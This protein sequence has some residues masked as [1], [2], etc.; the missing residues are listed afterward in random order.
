MP[1]RPKPRCGRALFVCPRRSL[2]AFGVLRL[3][4]DLVGQ[5]LVADAAWTPRYGLADL[6]GAVDDLAL[7]PGPHHRDMLEQFGDVLVRL[8]LLEMNDIRPRVGHCLDEPV[9]ARDVV[10][11]RQRVDLDGQVAFAGFRLGVGD[12][13]DAVQHA[14]EVAA[15]IDVLVLLLRRPRQADP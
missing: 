10:T 3:G 12:Q 6:H 1:L 11:E 4:G 7:D 9:E 5:V 13:F 15:D 14:L 2:Q 8:Q